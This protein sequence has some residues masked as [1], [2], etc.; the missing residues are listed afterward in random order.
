MNA[1]SSALGGA[2]GGRLAESGYIRAKIVQE[3]LIRESALPYSLVHATQFFEFAKG[4]ADASTVGGTVRLPPVLFQPI[5]AADVSK[6]VGKIA[7]GAPLNGFIEIAGPAPFRLDEFVRRGLSARNDPREVTSDPHARYF[8]AELGERTLLPGDGAQIGETSFE[9]WFAA[10]MP[11]A[12]AAG[13]LG[14]LANS[15]SPMRVY[16]PAIDWQDDPR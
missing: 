10:S 13:E 14:A 16:S 5:A 7:V 1:A 3:K 4:I 15:V 2:S 9:E 6:A 8:G 11:A 12:P